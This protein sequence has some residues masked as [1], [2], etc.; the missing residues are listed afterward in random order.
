VLKII[1]GEFKGRKLCTASGLK[2]RPT[3]SRTREA[4]FNI[5]GD[6]VHGAHVLDLFAGSGAFGI[7]ALSRGAATALFIETEREALAALSHNI[8]LCRLTERAEIIRWNAIR[9]LDCLRKHDPLFSLIFLDPPYHR[10]LVAPTLSHLHA[11]RSIAQ[12]ARL[13]IEH[14][15]LDPLPT[16][17]TP[18]VLEDQR[19]Y[20]KSLV[21]F[22]AY[23]I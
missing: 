21:S 3:A 20:G 8:K 2:T 17:R 15:V 1:S 16:I 10:G 22:L 9:N 19:R 23:V 12:G 18:Y 13:V 5:I 14:G 6:E 11:V 7:E 4:I